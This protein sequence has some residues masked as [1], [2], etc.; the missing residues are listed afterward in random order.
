VIERRPVQ[1][2]GATRALRS[3]LRGPVLFPGDAGYDDGRRVWNGMIDRRPALIVRAMD[4]GDVVKAVNFARDQELPLAVRGG[5]H[6]VAGF[7]TC[8][9]GLVLDLSLMRGVEVSPAARTARV[10][11]GAT[12]ADVDAATQAH[13]LATPGGLVS[14]TGVG[15]LTLGGGIG[16]LMRKHGLTCDNL[17]WVDLV[18]AGGKAITASATEHPDLFWAVRGGGGNFGVVTSFKYRLYQVG[19]VVLGGA[20]FHPIAKAP[21]LLRF[22]RDWAQ[23]L[24]DELTTMVAFL[25]APPEPFVPDHLQGT[26]MVAV[27]LCYAGP[28]E[29]GQALVRPL[30]EFAEPAIDLIGPLPYTALQ[31]MFDATAPHGIHAYWKTAYLNDLG[32]AVIDT[33]LEHVSRTS[34]LSPFAVVHIHQVGGAVGRVDK[35]ETAFTHRSEPYILNIVGLWM[36]QEEPASHIAW[37]R[38]FSEDVRPFSAGAEYVNF[39]ADEGKDRVKAAYGPGT[40]ERL[41]GLKKRYDPD[42]L[43]RLNQNILPAA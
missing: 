43:F 1:N 33:A 18:T 16:W 40:Y 30:R 22:Y 20:L 36:A 24:P 29:A 21:A 32:D 6:N 8:D 9:D 23:T 17:L 39:L 38:T 35:D 27:A 5:G 14:A 25:T 2:D 41:A 3:D 28:V 10:A 19:P 31:S 12:L 7:G 4:P 34:A 15:G 26:P 42:N 13:G 37:A 11:G